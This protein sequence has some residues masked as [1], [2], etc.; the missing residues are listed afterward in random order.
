MKLHPVP[1][2]TPDAVPV[3]GLHAVPLDGNALSQ[4]TTQT[5]THTHP[6]PQPNP[7][8]GDV[9]LAD[10]DILFVAVATKLST[11]PLHHASIEGQGVVQQCVEALNQ[12]RTTMLHEI[13]RAAAREAV[14]RA[15]LTLAESD[16][17]DARAKSLPNRDG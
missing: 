17:A 5:Y 1:H 2:D 12:L 13:D 15:L 6:P 8:N 16:L 9:A 7:Q 4:T 11:L 10:W 3:E 14:L